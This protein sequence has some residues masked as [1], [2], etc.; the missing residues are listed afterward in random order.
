MKSLGWILWGFVLWAG[1]DV[2]RPLGPGVLD[3]V[4]LLPGLD[5]AG[6]APADLTGTPAPVDLAMPGLDIAVAGPDLP[7]PDLGM[8]DMGGADLALPVDLA[9]PPPRD[10]AGGGMPVGAVVINEVHPSNVNGVADEDGEK[11]DW[12]E[13][14]NTTAS[15][16]DLTGVGLSTKPNNPYEWTFPAGAAIAAKQFLVVFASSKNRT[17][18]GRPLHT[19]YTINNGVDSVSLTAPGRVQLDNFAPAR[20]KM[21]VSWCRVPDAM[22]PFQ[23]CMMPTPGASNGGTAYPSMLTPP[24]FSVAGGFYNVA[25]NVELVASDPGAIVRYTLDTTDPRSTRRST[26]RPSRSARCTLRAPTS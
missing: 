20:S 18:P 25:Q 19:N 3:D 4:E 10:M 6:T 22:G 15:P 12:I 1:C 11:D 8:I 14:Y 7:V 5:L 21:D 26:R 2:D 9:P 13:L 24:S 16:I 17:V 23:L